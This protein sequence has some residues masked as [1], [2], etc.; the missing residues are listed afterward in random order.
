MQ[1]GEYRYLNSKRKRTTPPQESLIVAL[2]TE[3]ALQK[4]VAAA[5]I[6]PMEPTTP[7]QESLIV[8]LATENALQKSVAA[9]AITTNGAVVT[10]ETPAPP[11]PNLH[12]V[13]AAAVGAVAA[14]AAAAVAPLAP[15]P[16]DLTTMSDQDLLSYINPSTF[17]QVSFYNCSLR[18]ENNANSLYCNNQEDQ[19]RNN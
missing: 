15:I 16:Q 2:A 19:Y 4:S 8:A 1:T 17:D 9:A 5:A 18:D 11:T 12:P 13:A 6:T 7:P 3:N 14:A 10:Q